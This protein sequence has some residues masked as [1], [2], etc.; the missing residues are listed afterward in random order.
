MNNDSIRIDLEQIHQSVDKIIYT[1]SKKPEQAD[2]IYNFFSYYLPAIVKIIDHVDE[3]ENQN[4]TSKESITF[5]ENSTSMIHE[6]NIAFEKILSK[7]YQSDIVDSDAEMKV[8]NT[9]LKSD[10]INEEINIEEEK[11]EDYE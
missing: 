9:M 5:L 6:A 8:F 10:G 2:N 3:I 7:L 4:L 1:I 11:E